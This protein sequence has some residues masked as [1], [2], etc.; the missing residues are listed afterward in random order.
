MKRLLSVLAVAVLLLAGYLLWSRS[1]L[2][3]D[4]IAA[5]ETRMWRAYYAANLPALQEELVTMLR[6]QFGLSHSD[7]NSIGA[8][9]ATAA[10]KF[11]IGPGTYE[12]TVLPHL[13]EAYR[14]LGNAKKLSFDPR[15]AA[16]AELK[17]WETRRQREPD[18]TPLVGKQIGELYGI[19][20]GGD[21]PEFARAG[22]LRAQAGALRD[23]GGANADW[24]KVEE[25]LRESYETLARG[26][27]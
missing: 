15:R 9:L 25:L 27:E 3:P 14:E 10:M 17:W 11:E 23:R 24:K 2:H 12:I 20:Y 5:A 6:A 26:V 16:R 18:P 1:H 8:H 7:A 22:E 19:I 21:R 13:E 4:R